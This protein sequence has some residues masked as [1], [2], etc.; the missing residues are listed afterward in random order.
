MSIE[1][2]V[3][4]GGRVGGIA[5]VEKQGV[6][7][8]CDWVGSCSSPEGWVVR[9]SVGKDDLLVSAVI[10]LEVLAPVAGVEG[11]GEDDV[12]VGRGLCH[13]DEGD[14]LLG[15]HDRPRVKARRPVVVSPPGLGKPCL[16]VIR[17]RLAVWNA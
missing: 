6:Q 5:G 14:V 2:K 15:V 3:V 9:P 17:A 16:G 4:G 8:Q 13:L 11:A 7:P 10:Y 1:I 12:G